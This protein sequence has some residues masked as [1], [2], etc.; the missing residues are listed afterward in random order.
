MTNQEIEDI[1]DGIEAAQQSP[2]E[3]QEEASMGVALF[4]AFC[5]GKIKYNNGFCEIR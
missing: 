3:N 4:S 2:G 1:M 5:V